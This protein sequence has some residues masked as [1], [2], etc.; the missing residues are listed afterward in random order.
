MRLNSLLLSI[1]QSS[2]QGT[3]LCF[4]RSSC[5]ELHDLAVVLDRNAFEFRTHIHTYYF[6]FKCI[7]HVLLL[8]GSSVRSCTT[9]LFSLCASYALFEGTRLPFAH[10]PVGADAG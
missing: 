1:C 10:P 5:S 8:F 4:V 6:H 3:P 7:L 2:C 9:L